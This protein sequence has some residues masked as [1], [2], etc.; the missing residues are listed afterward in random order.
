MTDTL[1]GYVNGRYEVAKGGQEL[2][3]INVKN[4]VKFN[5]YPN[6]ILILLLIIISISVFL[7]LRKIIL[8]QHF[9]GTWRSISEINPSQIVIM[10]NSL[11]TVKYDDK[12]Y[13]IHHSADNVIMNKNSGFFHIINKKIYAYDVNDNLIGIYTKVRVLG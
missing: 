1:I 6:P 11:F 13:H 5:E 10:P 2:N 12:I 4:L 7:F 3:D 9:I 8:L